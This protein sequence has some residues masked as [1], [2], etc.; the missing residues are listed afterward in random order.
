MLK[1]TSFYDKESEYYSIKRYP[2]IPITYTHFFFKRRLCLAFNF[3]KS[4]Y[5]QNKKIVEIGCADGYVLRELY[6]KHLIKEKMIGIDLSKEMIEVAKKNSNGLPTDYY[7]RGEEP[8]GL[9]AD[10]LLE[11]GVIN[12]TNL[13]DELDYAATHL[14]KDAYF[15]VSFASNT[16]LIH[17]LDQSEEGEYV[18][19]ENQSFY[20]E[21]LKKEFKIIKSVPYG[22]F[23][24]YLWRI[25]KLAIII[26]PVLEKIFRYILPNLFHEEIYLAQKK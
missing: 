1:D 14:P 2:K 16:S 24:P 18:H 20:R 9:L 10:I 12:F 25:P 4:V 15:V 17:T 13:R 7:I 5:P 21:Q 23:V 6:K 26:Q 22:L 11:I 3:I 19:F 8:Q